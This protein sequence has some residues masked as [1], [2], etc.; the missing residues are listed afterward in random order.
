MDT[1]FCEFNWLHFFFFLIF[2]SLSPNDKNVFFSTVKSMYLQRYKTNVVY[3]NNNLVR[4]GRS[5]FFPRPFCLLFGAHTATLRKF[6]GHQNKALEIEL[7]SV[8]QNRTKNGKLTTR[9]N[10][11]GKS[12]LTRGETSTMVDV[13]KTEA[14]KKK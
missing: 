8:I 6:H 5:I 7:N 4:A 12:V 3:S 1:I 10:H 14:F 2:E 13:D 11:K 9:T